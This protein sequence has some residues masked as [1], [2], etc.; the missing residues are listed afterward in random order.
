M[1]IEGKRGDSNGDMKNQHREEFVRFDNVS[2]KRTDVLVQVIA[3]STPHTPVSTWTTWRTLAHRP[4]PLE[5][6]SL[7][8]QVLADPKYFETC[9][10]CDE[11]SPLGWM[12]SADIC[13]ACAQKN[14]GVV[15]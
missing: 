7:L 1:P 8:S 12:H 2:E 5:R 4:D 11:R 15:Y 14:H 13:Q 10:E 9:A 6:G 3:W